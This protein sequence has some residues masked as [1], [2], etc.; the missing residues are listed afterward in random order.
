MKIGEREME[1]VR[2]PKNVQI[3]SLCVCFSVLEFS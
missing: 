2:L 1:T 3:I